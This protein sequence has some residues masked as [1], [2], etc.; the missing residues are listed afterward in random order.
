[1]RYT[2]ALVVGVT[3]LCC[4]P[5]PAWPKYPALTRS[6]NLALCISR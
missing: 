1:M 5:P 4:A 6:R 3:A 2:F